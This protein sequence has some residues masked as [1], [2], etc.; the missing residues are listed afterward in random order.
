MVRDSGCEFRFCC[1]GRVVWGF[2]FVRCGVLSLLGVLVAGS[3]RDK[4]VKLQKTLTFELLVVTSTPIM[5]GKV[6]TGQMCWRT[7]LQYPRIQTSHILLIPTFSFII[8]IGT[9][10]NLW[11]FEVWP[12]YYTI[13]RLPGPQIHTSQ[14]LWTTM[15]LAKNHVKRSRVGRLKAPN[16]AM[17]SLNCNQTPCSQQEGCEH[18]EFF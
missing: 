17:L 4:L 18:E 3:L 12:I 1:L 8:G 7:R 11:S 15:S 16:L 2:E 6:R 5:D 14:T 10:C 13:T 9:S